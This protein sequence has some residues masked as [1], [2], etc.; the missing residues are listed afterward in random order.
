MQQSPL[1]WWVCQD[2]HCVVVSHQAGCRMQAGEVR[3][4]CL[5]LI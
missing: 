2:A 5:C 4:C 1:H 3:G